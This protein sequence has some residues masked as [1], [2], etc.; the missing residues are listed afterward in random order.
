MADSVRDL[1]FHEKQAAISRI[2]NEEINFILSQVEAAVDEFNIKEC[3]HF[4][5]GVLN[6]I[7]Y[8]LK[9]GCSLITDT[10]LVLGGLDSEICSKLSVNLKCF[11]DNP[12]VINQAKY[13][14][15]TRAEIAV[16]VALAI[17]GPKIMVVGSAPMA[18]KRI[19]S[20]HSISPLVETTVIAAANGFANVVEIKER[21]W[22]SGLPC[23]VVRGR[24]GGVNTAIAIT[25]VLLNHVVD[26]N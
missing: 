11:L 20:V 18:L 19:L 26:R 7:E 4:T 22:D 21:I 23:V 17:Q 6:R 1:F 3:I 16:D 13:K 24:N 15:V 5:S 2:P 8:H 14:R 25:N 10:K 9:R 12:Q